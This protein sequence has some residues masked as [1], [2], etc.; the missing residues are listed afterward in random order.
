MIPLTPTQNS[1]HPDC[2]CR[3]HPAPGLFTPGIKKAQ[4]PHFLRLGLFLRPSCDHR[5]MA[6]R[7]GQPRGWP[8]SFLTGSEQPRTTRLHSRL[9]TGGDGFQLK[10]E[11]SMKSPI[12]GQNPPENRPLATLIPFKKPSPVNYADIIH[13]VYKIHREVLDLLTLLPRKESISEINWS[14]LAPFFAAQKFIQIGESRVIK[15]MED[16]ITVAPEF[17]GDGSEEVLG[18]FTRIQNEGRGDASSK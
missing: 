15:L 17:E 3:T 10:K 5:V 1:G 7:A 18:F 16:G 9:F 8:V 14:W 6:E 11:P 4:C 12:P 13:R 2:A